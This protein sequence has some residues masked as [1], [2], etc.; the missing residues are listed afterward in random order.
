MTKSETV[1]PQELNQAFTVQMEEEEELT[2][3]EVCIGSLC[4]L[5][6]YSTYVPPPFY[7][8]LPHRTYRWKVGAKLTTRL[9]PQLVIKRA[10]VLP[11]CFG[12][13]DNGRWCWRWIPLSLLLG[14]K[15]EP[16]MQKKCDHSFPVHAHLVPNIRLK[17]LTPVLGKLALQPLL[18][19]SANSSAEIRREFSVGQA[20]LSIRAIVEVGSCFKGFNNSPHWA[21]KLDWYSTETDKVQSKLANDAVALQCSRRFSLTQNCKLV[22]SAAMQIPSLLSYP[23]SH[24]NLPEGIKF[25][26]VKVAQNFGTMASRDQPLPISAYLN[27]SEGFGRFKT[28]T[29]APGHWIDPGIEQG[30]P[31]ER[32]F[33]LEIANFTEKKLHN[34]GWEVLRPDRDAPYLSWEEYLN[35][36]SKQTLKGRP[37]LEIHGQGSTADYR[38][39]VFGIIGDAEAS[40][41]KELAKDFGIFPMDWRELGV[42]R[43]GGVIV[44]SFNADKVMRMAPLQRSCAVRHIANSIVSCIERA[45][46]QNHAEHSMDIESIDDTF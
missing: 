7:P 9:M 3:H 14:L 15:V 34:K 30:A 11:N 35:W 28:I 29:I 32:D 41:N 8:R 13:G 18:E 46:S 31:G 20:K 21:I 45:S 27:A 12:L 5:Q 39:L 19:L 22:A 38:G 2:D 26:S 10:L 42:P 17:S 25:W 4:F 44:E 43:R 6:P 40:L 16:H 33:N 24:R 37:V 1:R 23:I 36:V